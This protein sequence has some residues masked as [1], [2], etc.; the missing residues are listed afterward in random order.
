MYAEQEVSR[1]RVRNPFVH[2]HHC[3]V[4]AGCHLRSQTLQR[5]IGRARRRNRVVR[6]EPAVDVVDELLPDALIAG[7]NQNYGG[8]MPVMLASFKLR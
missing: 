3:G 5:G 8:A 1:R 2:N 6:A 4:G 7:D